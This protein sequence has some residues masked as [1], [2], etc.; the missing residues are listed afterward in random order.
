MKNESKLMKEML[1]EIKETNHSIQEL[2]QAISLLMKKLI[3]ESPG[4][5]TI[6]MGGQVAEITVRT[7][8]KLKEWRR[9]F[10]S[11]GMRVEYYEPLRKEGGQY[12]AK[13]WGYLDKN[14]L[15]EIRKGKNQT[16]KRN[17]LL[18]REGVS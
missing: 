17:V 8:E 11:R 14:K 5:E 3:P 7:P 16:G 4:S 6:K 15:R 13:L 10:E 9:L 2:N 1:K 12:F 18:A